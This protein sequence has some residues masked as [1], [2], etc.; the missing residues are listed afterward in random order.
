MI[1][2]ERQRFEYEIRQP[3]GVAQRPQDDGGDSECA[4]PCEFHVAQRALACIEWQDRSPMNPRRSK[5]S[6]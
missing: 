2:L 3:Q 4:D 6:R 5:K 1:E